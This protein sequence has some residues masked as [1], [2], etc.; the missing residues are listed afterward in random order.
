MLPLAP[1]KEPVT[2]SATFEGMFVRALQ[3]TGAFAEELRAAGYDV[4]NPRAEYPTR[5]WNACLEVARRHT[6]PALPRAEGQH[7]LGQ[8]FMEGYFRTLQGK[9]AGA[10][11]PM[12]G[13]AMVVKKL[14]QAWSASQPDIQMESVELGPGEWRVTLGQEG[15]VAEFCAGFIESILQRTRVQPEAK[16][17]EVSP[18]GCILSV[19]WRE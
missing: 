10:T 16:V 1:T 8:L 13:P 2:R 5:V 9:L 14:R 11:L 12:L 18:T 7:R 3:P 19:R 6:F 4:L 15:I 17:L